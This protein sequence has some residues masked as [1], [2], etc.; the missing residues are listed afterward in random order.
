MGCIRSQMDA[1]SKSKKY[2]M[3]EDVVLKPLYITDSVVHDTDD[4]A[5][6]FNENNPE[7][8]LIIG[9]DKDEDGAFVCF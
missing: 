9:T 2:L 8:S 6:W 5:I 7:L 4:P 1:V 3:L